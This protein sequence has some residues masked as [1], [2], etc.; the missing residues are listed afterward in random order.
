MYIGIV[1]S[2]G[3][4]SYFIYSSF[5]LICL[6]V[7]TIKDLTHVPVFHGVFYSISRASQFTIAADMSD[8]VK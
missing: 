4:A 1:G 5:L 8:S 2:I 3:D 6:A 7:S